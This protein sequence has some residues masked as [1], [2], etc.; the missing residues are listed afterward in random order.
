MDIVR[1]DWLDSHEVSNWVHLNDLGPIEP[2]PV[3][4]VGVLLGEADHAVRVTGHYALET[5]GD[6]A[7]ACGVMTIPRCCIR[8]IITIDRIEE[9]EAR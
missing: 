1:I 3:I 4:T 9:G 5:K 2:Q 6:I 8:S 7:Q